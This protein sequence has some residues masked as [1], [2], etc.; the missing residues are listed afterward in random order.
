[1]R[2]AAI[3]GWADSG[4][5]DVD[6]MC[7]MLNVSRSGY[8]AW[9]GRS[10]SARAVDDISIT[11]QIRAHFADAL[12]NPGVRRIHAM[13][14]AAGRVIGR[15]RVLRLMQAAGLA[16]RHPRAA[17]RTTVAGVA[18]VSAP[19][20]IGRD[21]TAEE[22]NTRWCGDITYVKT[23]EEWAY[24]ATVID[25]HSRAVVGFAVADH[26]HTSLIVEALNM[27]IVHR[28]PPPGVIFHSDRGSQYTSGEFAQYCEA[29]EIRRS[30]GR[31]GICYD[32]AVAESFFATY[33]KELVHTRPW[34]DV[35]TLRRETFAWI[36]GYYN[37]RR[38]HSTLDYLTPV[39]FELGYRTIH[40]IAALAA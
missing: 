7:E 1:V 22:A 29:N 23:W 17:R 31:T 33:K 16:G 19:D 25:L 27:A 3:A 9:R 6:F 18:P 13:L 14:R 4:E 38:R 37:T 34:P 10:P 39:E 26:M 28:A 24:V 11:A 12:G 30:R 36:E 20:L 40:Q 8:Y 32:N 21:F 15:R 35:Q 5:F 2:F